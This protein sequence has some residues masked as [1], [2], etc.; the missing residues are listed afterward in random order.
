MSPAP[1]LG[2]THCHAKQPMG[3]RACSPGPPAKSLF[4]AGGA[5][6]APS[7]GQ[8]PRMT[9]RALG[10]GAP[11]EDLTLIIARFLCGSSSE[12]GDRPLH[13]RPG[14]HGGS[15]EAPVWAWPVAWRGGGLSRAQTPGFL[16]LPTHS[17]FTSVSMTTDPRNHTAHSQNGGS[18][19]VLTHTRVKPSN[20]K[21]T[22]QG[23]ILNFRD[24]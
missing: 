15:A 7:Q 8:R 22:A 1:V 3:R 19:P 17:S 4:Q 6:P 18:W 2:R 23:E 20:R 11:A 10:L 12:R 13:H 16:P 24:S 14:P 21:E 9:C 5:C